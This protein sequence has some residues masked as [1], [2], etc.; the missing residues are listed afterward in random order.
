MK[1]PESLNSSIQPL[2]KNPHHS[3]TDEVVGEKH[4]PEALP[5]NHKSQ[6]LKQRLFSN[7]QEKPGLTDLMYS[8]VSDPIH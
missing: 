5:S 1:N 6:Y 3:L 4:K 7:C 2:T 8:T